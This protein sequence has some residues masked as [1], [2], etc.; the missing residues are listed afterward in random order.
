M[1]QGELGGDTVA[2]LTLKLDG[3]FEGKQVSID[4][5]PLDTVAQ[6][7]DALRAF[8]RATSDT[9]TAASVGFG[10]G[11]LAIYQHLPFDTAI[12]LRASMAL[13]EVAENDPYINLVSSLVRAVRD[14]DLYI[15]FLEGDRELLRVQSDGVQ[16]NIVE[17]AWVE[18]TT[19]IFGQLIDLGGKNPNIHVETEEYGRLRIDATREQIRRLQAYTYYN[20]SI[21]CEMLFHDT[22]MYRQ[23]KLR[24]FMIAHGDISIFEA[25]A[26]ESAKWEGIG[27]IAGWVRSVRGDQ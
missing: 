18:T 16:L 20:F 3:M 14:R 27:D 24:D 17:D 23:C 7:L 4:N 1:A 22:I 10:T 26:V 6:T 12:A 13:E 8:V 19:T 15:S 2:E 11:S 21:E 5:A 25:I 9:P